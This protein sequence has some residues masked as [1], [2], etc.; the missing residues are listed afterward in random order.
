MKKL[1][2]AFCALALLMACGGKQT[3][4]DTIQT[5]VQDSTESDTLNLAEAEEV[6]PPRADEL[7]DDFIYDFSADSGV[8]RARTYFP[9][10]YTTDGEQVT[11]KKKEWQHDPLFSNRDFYTVIFN[12]ESE[13]ELEKDT[14]LTQV[15]LEFLDLTKQRA[16]RYQFKR[17]QGVGVWCLYGVTEEPMN[18]DLDAVEFLD[19]YQKFV[20]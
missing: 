10:P 8:Q 18:A 11:I 6:L 15:R 1:V 7:F 12:D 4:E 9:F 14:S 17:Y 19:F 3:Q 5:V 16:K 13:M 20:G 2:W